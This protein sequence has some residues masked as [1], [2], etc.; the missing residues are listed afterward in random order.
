MIGAL[1]GNPLTAILPVLGNSLASERQRKRI[2]AALADID[3]ILNRHDIALRNLTDEQYKLI[4]EA[5]L[6]L[7]QTTNSA[8]IDYLRRA[9]QNS[10]SIESI[11]FQEAAVLS[12]I[13]RDISADEVDFLFRNFEYERILILP[14]N[15]NHESKVLVV[16]PGSPDRLVVT[17]LVSLGL[18]ESGSS[19]I[20]DGGV[21]KFSA[22]VIKLMVLLNKNP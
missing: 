6:A 1:S 17:G 4:N 7:F 3:V 12:R 14:D 19:T 20:G 5:I 13:I 22:I 16:H 15:S 18:L 21:L 11:Q 9:V 2:E 8:K 10:L